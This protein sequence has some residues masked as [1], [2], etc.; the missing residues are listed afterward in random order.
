[1]TSEVPKAITLA[2]DYA[3][4]LKACMDTHATFAAFKSWVTHTEAIVHAATELASARDSHERTYWTV[5]LR[6]AIELR[7]RL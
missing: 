5:E 2:Q 7:N 1:M 6:K 4:H 3:T